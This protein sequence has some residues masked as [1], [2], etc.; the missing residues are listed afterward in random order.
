MSK[1]KKQTITILQVIILILTII[2]TLW[3]CGIVYSWNQFQVSNNKVLSTNSEN[4][5]HLNKRISCLEG[6][7]ADCEK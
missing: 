2:N 3:L 4:N 1:D 5:I 7:K 6:N